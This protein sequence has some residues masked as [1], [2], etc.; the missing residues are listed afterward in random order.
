MLHIV[1]VSN[2][3]MLWFAE[4]STQCSNKLSSQIMCKCDAYTLSCLWMH[5]AFQDVVDLRGSDT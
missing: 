4:C 1:R 5:P 3:Y 2:I